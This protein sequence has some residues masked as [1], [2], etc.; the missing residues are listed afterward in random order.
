M[1]IK[2]DPQKIPYGK[3]VQEFCK[4]KYPGYKNGCPNYG[5]K[6]GC[7]PCTLINKILDF[8]K[9]VFLIYTE[10][11]VLEFSKR[12]KSLHP[13]WTEKQCRNSRL[14]QQKARKLHRLEI[15]KFKKEYG[16]E[17]VTQPE[18]KGVDVNLLFARL[19]MRLQWPPKDISRVV[20]LGGTL[21]N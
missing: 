7:P 8:N 20:S 13:N 3:Y 5:K 2:L 4:N 10:F 9:P 14:W 17:I 6:D 12:M 18:R 16:L 19:G 15:E 11:N 21:L 1:I